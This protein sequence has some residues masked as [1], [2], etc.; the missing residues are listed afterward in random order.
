[1][2]RRIWVGGLLLAL[3]NW[4]E[5]LTVSWLTI[6]ATGSPLATAATFA[7]RQAP[8]ILVAPIAGALTDRLP[9]TL[10]LCYGYICSICNTYIYLVFILQVRRRG[11]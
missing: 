4:S 7:A 5:R 2:F 6:T 1:M 9:R 3:A 10:V 8:G 11:A